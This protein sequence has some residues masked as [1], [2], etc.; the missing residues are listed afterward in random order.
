MKLG[1]PALISVHVPSPERHGFAPT[2]TLQQAENAILSRVQPLLRYSPEGK[3]VF[4][5]RLSLEGNP[6][7]KGEWYEQNGVTI[8]P[9]HWALGQQ[10]FAARLRRLANDAPAPIELT[11]WLA[12][13]EAAREGKSPYIA[14][15]DSEGNSQ[16]LGVDPALTAVTAQLAHGWRTL[17]ELAG[18]VT[19]FTAR[20]EAEAR[21]NL[22]A[23]HQAE[24]DA[25]HAEYEAKLRALEEGMAARTHEQITQRLVELAGYNN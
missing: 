18:L 16:R 14:V 3:G 21:A 5:S 10:R 22:A 13:D 8:T 15:A 7:L 23:S 20:V 25:L 24:I 9:A 4:G 17:Q 1:G 6:T 11:A 2:E 12:L 19:P